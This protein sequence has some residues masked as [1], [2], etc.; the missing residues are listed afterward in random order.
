MVVDARSFGVQILGCFLIV[1]SCAHVQAATPAE[2]DP[3]S[4]IEG[5][6]RW[7]VGTYTGRTPPGT[8]AA[9]RAQRKALD[10]SPHTVAYTGRDWA[11]AHTL[12]L[13]LSK[14]NLLAWEAAFIARTYEA[15]LIDADLARAWV[16]LLDGW[17]TLEDTE[18]I[19][20]HA[21][22][23]L[24]LMGAALG[25]ISPDCLPDQLT[26]AQALMDLAEI[27]TSTPGRRLRSR[28]E[29][30]P[31]QPQRA[32]DSTPSSTSK[33]AVYAGTSLVALLSPATPVLAQWDPPPPDNTDACA[34]RYAR[35]LFNLLLDPQIDGARALDDLAA[36]SMAFP[37]ASRWLWRLAIHRY[38]MGDTRGVQRLSAYYRTHYPSDAESVEIM[39]VLSDIAGETPSKARTDWPAA[40]AGSNPT[41]QWISAE[42]A[43][44]RGQNTAA[45]EALTR[46]TDTDVHFVAAWISLAAARNAL[47]RGHGVHIALQ[48]LEEIAPPLPIY[49]YWRTTLRERT[50]P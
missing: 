33:D 35:A 21:A 24:R 43:R 25:S 11:Q 19:Q 7:R 26:E 6:M 10:M 30:P 48:T 47:A 45:E 42:A 38:L 17:N 22:L 37:I 15:E 12:L 18:R 32:E 41:Y 2:I 13:S 14:E 50:G 39:R 36:Q 8:P 20:Q 3:W 29:P 49:D 9:W 16:Q 44:R 5:N 34:T 28:I 27:E 40:D 46:I 31:I 4:S 23:R 1:M